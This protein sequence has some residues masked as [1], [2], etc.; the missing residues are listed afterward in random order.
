M[1]GYLKESREEMKEA[2]QAIA[3]GLSEVR[4]KGEEI[5]KPKKGPARKK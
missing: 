2:V 1:A 5:P 3:V 4:E